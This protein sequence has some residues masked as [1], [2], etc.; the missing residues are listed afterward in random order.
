M[1]KSNLDNSKKSENNM[2]NTVATNLVRYRWLLMLISL[3]FTVMLISGAR[4][5]GFATDYEVWFSDDNPELIDFKQL[6]NTYDKSDNVLILITPKNGDVFSRQTLESIEWLTKQAWKIPYSTRVESLTNYQHTFSKGDDLIVADLVNNANSLSTST[7]SN[8][9]KVALT[10]PLLLHRIISEDAKVTAINVTVNLPKNSPA[11]TPTV[12]AYTRDLVAQLKERNP[13]L[14]THLSGLV[15]LDNAFMEASQKDMGSLTLIMFGLIILGL[16]VFL[17]SITGT[18]SILA[19]I[20]LSIMATVGAGGWFGVLLTPVSAGAPTIV[21]TIVVATS[22]H[23][24]ITMIHA[25]RAGMEKRDALVESL[26]VNIQPV[27]LATSTTIIGF[28]SMHFSGVPPF[29]DL[30]NMAAV[31]VF[32]ALVLSM[33]FLP[34]LLMLLPMR[35]SVIEDHSNRHMLGL[36]NFII[37]NHSKLLW[38]FTGITVLLI[39][40]IQN[41]V[42]N[43]KIWEY[44]EKSEQ[45]RIDTDYA[46]KKLTGPYYLEYSIKSNKIGGISN[47]TYLGTVDEF[48]GWLYTQPEVIHV[49]AITDI[50]KR[51]NK[52]LHEDNENWYRL[53]EEKNL[54]AQ[55]LLLYEMS[56]PYGLDLTNQINVDKSASRVVVSLQNLS[57]NELFAFQKRAAKWLDTHAPE[58]KHTESSPMFMFSNIGFRTVQQMVGGVAF[59]LIL[60][61]ILIIVA[62]KSFKIGLISLI[63]NLVPPA[64]AFGVWGIFIGEVGFALAVGLGMTIGIIVDDTVHFLSKYLRARREKGLGAEEAIRYTFSNV[65][66]AL[67]ITTIVLVAGFSVLIAST[68]KIN[69]DLGMITALTIG[70]ALIVD[71]ILLPALLL[72]F[73]TKEYSTVNNSTDNYNESTKLNIVLEE[74]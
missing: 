17:R 33:G 38:S 21:M 42:V 65:G 50:L 29:H 28:L 23:I 25:M 62:L 19:V 45:I 58:Y 4:F 34:W 16:V 52:N 31:G 48:Q 56:L 15:I 3:M 69:T 70:I 1:N 60:I 37:D 7:L 10:E 32:C 30:G 46:A 13:D 40:F 18:L 53:P 9:K 47:P 71:F 55:Y 22:V 20:I 72:K 35:V 39:A 61:S 51:L 73:D 2:I 57:N 11:G 64:I 54:A 66:T 44:F 41:N 68:F 24:L 12:T 43:D 67:I 5:I 36:S 49:N 6:Q 26:R 8:I 14:Q 59:A 27:L 74:G 63:P